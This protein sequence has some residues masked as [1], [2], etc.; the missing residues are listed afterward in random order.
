MT[1][2]EL[3]SRK[4]GAEEKGQG[5]RVEHGTRWEHHLPSRPLVLRPVPKGKAP[6]RMTCSRVRRSSAMALAM[7]EGLDGDK[8]I[9]DET[10]SSTSAEML[11]CLVFGCLLGFV[12]VVNRSFSG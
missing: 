11:C 9:S 4:C 8:G 5:R 12:G 1:R 7:G 6:V 10:N 3:L 2:A